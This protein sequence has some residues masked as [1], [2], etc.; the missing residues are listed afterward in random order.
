MG[1]QEV[2]L[3]GRPIIVQWHDTADALV[4][5]AAAETN[6]HLARR[7]RALHLIRAGQSISQTAEAIGVS[8]RTVE[9]WLDW[10]REGGPAE[11]VRHRRGKARSSVTNQVTHQHIE[12]LVHEAKTN[13]FES[14]QHAITWVT[15][16]FGVVI[17]N[18][19]MSKVFRTHG[20]RRD[21][22]ADVLSRLSSLGQNLTEE[23]LDDGDDSPCRVRLRWHVSGA[24]E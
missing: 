21:L 19:D 22:S 15:E 5:H 10:Y 7:W 14:Q 8:Y 11:L 1:N 3:V 13:G 6:P 20:I 12:A 24:R 2:A 9:N 17:S 18:K 23:W 4:R 16:R